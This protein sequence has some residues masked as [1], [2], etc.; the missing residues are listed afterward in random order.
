MEIF[1]GTEKMVAVAD[2]H[3]SARDGRASDFGFEFGG[4]TLFVH[5]FLGSND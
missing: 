2:R 4:G 3:R 1:A 5:N